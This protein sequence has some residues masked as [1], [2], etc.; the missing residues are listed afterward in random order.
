MDSQRLKTY[1]T[2][3]IGSLIMGIAINT[4][5]VPT[6]LLSMGISGIAMISY[7]LFGTPIGIGG[8]V[9]NIPLFIIAYRLLNKSYI[10]TAFYGMIVASLA[11]DFTSF[12]RDWNL[13]SDPLLASI[14][15]GALFG[16]AS[17]IVFRVN[18]STGGTDILAAIFRKYYGIN[19]GFFGFLFNGV[20]MI[21]A[22][23]IFDIEIAMYTL[24]SIFVCS[25]VTDKVVAGFN[26]K[27]AIWIV[28]DHPEEIAQRIFATMT[29]GVTYL[30]GVG[31]YT[32]KQ[33][34]VLYIVV[35]LTQTP[36]IREIIQQ[37]DPCAFMTIQ[38]VSEVLGAGKG[39]SKLIQ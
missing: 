19:M 10:I 22:A 39:F 4:F 33:K 7:F 18:G 17:G 3:L 2:I 8:F 29:R 28:T 32:G 1:V 12:A 21:V 6:H 23:F 34:K 37:A 14:Y 16:F 38:D 24:L 35:T 13:V 25:Q 11:I 5:F 31:A 15:G 20:V 9:L 36:K 30:D 26:S 27:K